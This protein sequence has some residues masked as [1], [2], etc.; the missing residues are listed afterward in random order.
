MTGSSFWEEQLPEVIPGVTSYLSSRTGCA[1]C[2]DRVKFR[3]G[4]NAVEDS[5]PRVGP[6]RTEQGPGAPARFGWAG[7]SPP[8]EGGFEVRRSLELPVPAGAK[9]TAVHSLF[10][11][12]PGTS[13]NLHRKPPESCQS[14]H[15]CGPKLTPNLTEKQL[16]FSGLHWP[17][18][19]QQQSA[20]VGSS[21]LLHWSCCWQQQSAANLTAPLAAAANAAAANAAA[22]APVVV[23]VAAEALVLVAASAWLAAAPVWLVAAGLTMK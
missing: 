12:I 6:S 4:G 15:Y 23:V 13:G 10:L 17:C 16:G 5:Q 8:S 9:S 3:G 14:S 20:A 22:A 11:K 19:W 18:C 21:N 7:S 1:R 2:D